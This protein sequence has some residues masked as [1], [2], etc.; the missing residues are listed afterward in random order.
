MWNLRASRGFTVGNSGSRFQDFTLV[1]MNFDFELLLF[2]RIAVNEPLN[3]I[4]GMFHLVFCF[5]VSFR[6]TIDH[7]QELRRPFS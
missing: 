1:N 3:D 4:L 7:S 6:A 2:G 5:F